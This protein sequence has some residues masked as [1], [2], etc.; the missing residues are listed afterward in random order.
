MS[1]IIENECSVDNRTLFKTTNGMF[2]MGY[3]VVKPGDVVTLLWGVK[4]L[5]ILRPGVGGGF[6]YQDDAYVDG[7]MYGEFLQTGPIP[8]DFFIH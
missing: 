5:V 4:A 2:G 8:E 3:R 6:T 7:I 1:S